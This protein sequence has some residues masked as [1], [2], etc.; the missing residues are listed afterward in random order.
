[1]FGTNDVYIF[2]AES[3]DFYLR[4]I[5][6]ETIQKDIV[7]VLYTF[8]NRPEFPEKTILFNQIVIKIA[9]DYDLPL[10]NLWLAIK[11]LPDEGV[12]PVQPIHLSIPPDQKTGDFVNNLNYGYTVRNLITLQAL[13]I[14]RTGLASAP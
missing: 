3:F 8:P 4:T 13:D 2:E 5:V 7:P 14:L 11:D 1:M 6:L 12:D 9:I 10:V